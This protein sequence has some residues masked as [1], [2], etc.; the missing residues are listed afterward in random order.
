MTNLGWGGLGAAL[1]LAAAM[2]AQPGAA[3][4]Y[5][6]EQ[7]QACT[8]DAFRLC[9]SE[10]PDVDRVTAC[11]LQ[12]KSELTP[13]CR[14]QFGPEPRE[15]ANAPSAGKPKTFRP[16]KSHKAKMSRKREDN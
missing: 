8:N 3:N 10:I 4:A 14:V 7:Q 5:T 12:H 11:M 2:V 15:A 16:R 6:A 9:S 1:L 13:E